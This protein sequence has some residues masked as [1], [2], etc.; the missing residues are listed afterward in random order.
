M[1]YRSGLKNARITT[2]FQAAS[3]PE[4]R[5]VPVV[6]TEQSFCTKTESR[7]KNLGQ[8]FKSLLIQTLPPIN[9]IMKRKKKGEK[10]KK[11]KR[12]RIR[13]RINRSFSSISDSTTDLLCT[14]PRRV[15]NFSSVENGSSHPRCTLYIAGT[16]MYS[17]KIHMC[18]TW[19]PF[20]YQIIVSGHYQ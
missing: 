14:S 18:F 8:N 7:L 17:N 6:S 1:V 2:S 9:K 19:L 20:P 16:R 12:N 15:L 4:Q 11:N 13:E 10:E 3:S 5:Y